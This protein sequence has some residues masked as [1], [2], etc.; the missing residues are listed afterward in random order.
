[1]SPENEFTLPASNSTEHNAHLWAEH[2]NNTILPGHGL[3][4][5]FSATPEFEKPAL[6]KLQKLGWILEKPFFIRK[7]EATYN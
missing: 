6:S 2:Y 1:M 7:Q 3:F 4:F 5:D